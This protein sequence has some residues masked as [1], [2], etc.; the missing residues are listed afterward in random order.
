MARTRIGQ[1]D[2]RVQFQ[3]STEGRSDTGEATPTWANLG[4]PAWA[5]VTQTGGSKVTE[6]DQL[7]PIG[8]YTVEVRRELAAG[9][10]T[11]DR[12]VWR[13]L[14]LYPVAIADVSPRSETTTFTCTEK[15]PG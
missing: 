4:A 15:E 6:A 7:V 3:R 5:R 11:K 9:K 10:T 1:L 8:T 14:T 2:E 12:I 13:G